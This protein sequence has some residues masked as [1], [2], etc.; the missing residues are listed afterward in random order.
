MKFE[1]KYPI[2]RQAPPL[3][4]QATSAAV[5]ETGIKVIDLI[6][7]F[8]K[9][10]IQRHPDYLAITYGAHPPVGATEG[11]DETAQS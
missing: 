7:P 8:I 6:C 4:E 5:L 1:K 9:G 3:V 2:H 11:S 10:W